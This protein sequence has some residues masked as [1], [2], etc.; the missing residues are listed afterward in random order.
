MDSS[1]VPWCSRSPSLYRNAGC[2]K[3]FA[4]QIKQ[5]NTFSAAFDMTQA[6]HAPGENGQVYLMT[7]QE[8]NF[9]AAE[10]V[11]LANEG[12]SDAIA[13]MSTGTTKATIFG[14]EQLVTRIFLVGKPNGAV[15]TWQTGMF[16]GDSCIVTNGTTDT[17][18]LAKLA[19]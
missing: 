8:S 7:D 19:Q 3:V 13:F 6:P 14:E 15:F 12:L 17:E 9:I 2:P 16:I 10:R 18:L 11:E 5:G 4:A 1:P